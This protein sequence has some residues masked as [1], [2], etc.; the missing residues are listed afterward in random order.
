[1]NSGPFTAAQ[2]T[3]VTR[4]SYE[5]LNYWARIN[6]IKPSISP[7][8]GSGSRRQYNFQDLVAIF[9]ALKLRQTGIFGTSLV[10]VF[11]EFRKQGFEKPRVALGVTQRGRTIVNPSDNAHGP[12][13]LLLAFECDFTMA[14]A[15]VLKMLELE[16]KP[17]KK[18]AQSAT[19]QQ[20]A[21]RKTAKRRPA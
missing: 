18:P 2:V 16:L 19:M 10:G 13:Q 4:V 8:R 5:T 20:I 15:E 14:A 7:A 12:V 21:S 11:R 1:M 9:I 6:L 3:R 17:A